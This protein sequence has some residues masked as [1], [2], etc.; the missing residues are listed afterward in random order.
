M[1]EQPRKRQYRK[2]GSVDLPAPTP[3]GEDA[4]ANNSGNGETGGD[5]TQ[6]QTQYA[7][8]AEG[9]MG[10][11]D[12]L[13]AMTYHPN[14]IEVRIAYHPAPKSELIIANWSIPVKEGPTGYSTADGEFHPVEG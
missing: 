3:E 10:F 8:S 6:S 14:R 2:R 12:R 13:K 5:R 11:V 7:G 9:W 4:S 1:D